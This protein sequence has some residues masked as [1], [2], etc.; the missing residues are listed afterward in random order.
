MV[1]AIMVESSV[2]VSNA[3]ARAASRIPERTISEVYDQ[4]LA[5][6]KHPWSKRT[7][8]A[9][10]TARRWLMGV[11][12]AQTPVTEIELNG[13]TMRFSERDMVVV[14]SWTKAVLRATRQLVLFA[15][16]DKA[17]QAKLELYRERNL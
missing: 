17:S 9:H 7:A 11:F 1:R 4:F 3:A 10:E 2:I 12:G 14:R 15:Y 8:V 5:D 16:S 6:P 13:E